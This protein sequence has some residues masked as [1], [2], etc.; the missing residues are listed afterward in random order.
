MTDSTRELVRALTQV[1]GMPVLEWRN[2]Y[3]NSGS[4]HLG[5][6]IHDDARGRVG[7][8]RARGE[9]IVTIWG[10]SATFVTSSRGDQSKHPP[11]N[12]RDLELERLGGDVVSEA[13][14]SRASGALVVRFASSASLSLDM[15]GT[16]PKESDQWV[17]EISGV[18][19][20]IARSGPTII[21][22]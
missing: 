20:F 12:L 1:R 5:R 9:A 21:S 15:D 13:V 16:A 17:L 2:G 3:G 6:A 8:T 14:Y 19:T 18:G 7:R 11:V 4:L 10:A 22:E